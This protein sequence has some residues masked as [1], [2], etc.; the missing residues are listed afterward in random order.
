MAFQMGSYTVWGC[1]VE[2]TTDIS[3]LVNDI[4]NIENDSRWL[5]WGPVDAAK[6]YRSFTSRGM[7][8]RPKRLDRMTQNSG[9]MVTAKTSTYVAV[10]DANPVLDNVMYYE[11]IIDIIELNYS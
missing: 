9:V 7:C 3:L 4:S 2:I 10:G 8:F 6:S 11:R 5:A 1:H